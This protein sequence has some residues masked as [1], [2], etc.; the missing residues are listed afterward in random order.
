MAL[1][2][3]QITELEA[4]P[5]SELVKMLA[6][7]HE[8]TDR[9]ERRASDAE[10]KLTAAEKKAA[11]DEEAR[12]LAT[13]SE[14][15]KEK[16]ARVKAEEKAT[17]AEKRAAKIETDSAIRIAALA[18]GATAEDLDDIVVLVRARNPELDGTKAAEAVVAMKEKKPGLFGGGNGWADDDHADTGAANRKRAGV[19]E[20]KRTE[21]DKLSP[22]ARM[23]YTKKG[24]KVV[25]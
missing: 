22:A 21:F 18:N 5:A 14:T 12:S 4:K 10:G 3:E 8:I 13:A 2:K 25:D 20:M 15:E 24:G 11:E 9:Y 7:Q 6:A 1:T 19:K 23:E 16:A 17:A